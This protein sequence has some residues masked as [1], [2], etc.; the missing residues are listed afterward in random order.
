M[1]KRVEY[2]NLKKVLI[3]EVGKEMFEKGDRLELKK[4]VKCNIVCG[5]SKFNDL[6]KKYTYK[7][8]RGNGIRRREWNIV[9][10]DRFYK[11]LERLRNM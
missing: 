8:N 6:Y 10:Y 2:E 3:E 7:G 9:D 5:N 1:L 4:M 11:M